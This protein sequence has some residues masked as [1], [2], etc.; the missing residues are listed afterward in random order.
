MLLAVLLAGAAYFIYDQARA[1][2]GVPSLVE[3]TAPTVQVS[4]PPLESIPAGT[5]ELLKSTVVPDNDPY[6]LACRLQGVCNVPETLPAPSKPYQ[7]GDRRKFWIEN[8]DTSENFQVETTLRYITPHSYFW[9]EDGVQ[10]RDADIAAL[11]NTFEDKIYP[12]DRRFFGSEWTPGVDNDPHI[13]VLY[14]RG[15]GA[16]TAGYYSTPDEYNPEIRKYSNGAE[17]FVFNADSESLTEE[18][19][20]GTLAHEFQ[21]MIHWHLDLNESSWLNEGFSE[22]AAFLNGYSV[23][24][25]DYA[26]IQHPDLPLLDWTSLT[27]SPGITGAHYGQSFL[28]VTYFL[29]RFGDKATQAVVRDPE[30][31][32]TSIDDVLRTLQISDSE[33]G[34]PITADDVVMDWMDTMYLNDGSIGD[35]RYAYHDYPTAPQASATHEISSCPDAIQSGSV[36]QYGAEYIRISCAG[37]HV[38]TFTGSTAA[39]LLPVGAHSGKYAFWSNKGDSSDMRLTR[40]FDFTD[41]QT[42]IQFS[43]WTWYDIEKGYDYLYLEAS[44]DGKTWTILNTPSCT[45]QDLSGN[46]Y[47]CGYTAKSGGGETARWTQQTVDLSAYAGESVT[48]RFEYVTDA[49]LNGE[50]LLLDDMT[51]PASGYTAGFESNDGGWTP[52]GFVRVENTLPQTFMLSLILQGG[53]ATTVRNVPL[54]SDQTASV[55]ISLPPGDDAVLVLTGT[56][57]FTRLPAG[58]SLEVK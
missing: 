40:T 35:G 15:V 45:S 31:S 32:L 2:G 18:Y 58:Y 55:P 43:Y 47:G 4:R 49:A 5:E 8:S 44:T 57:R 33:T 39:Q 3:S 11:M 38:I 53:G 26:Y 46:S 34:Q 19:T 6:E 42:P 23:G 27:D 22:L 20:Y 14:V 12:T 9:A 13:Y 17:L 29:D 30:N 21:H 48:L 52:D 36:N 50:G 1:V 41:V 16:S 37:D 7:V 51:I 54:A 25:M 24:G 56:Q 10:A 28:F